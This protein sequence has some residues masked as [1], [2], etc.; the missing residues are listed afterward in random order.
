MYRSIESLCPVAGT[1][2]MLYFK[3]NRKNKLMEK[4]IRFAVLRGR[5][6]GE[7]KLDESGQEVETSS[8]KI[9]KY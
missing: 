4:E 8:C 5:A 7:G 1:N 9:N 6:W 2:I 3:N